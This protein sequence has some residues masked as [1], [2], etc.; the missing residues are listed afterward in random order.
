MILQLISHCESLIATR[1]I[2][3]FVNKIKTKMK[4]KSLGKKQ[5]LENTICLIVRILQLLSMTRLN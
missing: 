2:V 3:H 5:L 1:F 4:M